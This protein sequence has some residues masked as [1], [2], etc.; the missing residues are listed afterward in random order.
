MDGF[1]GDM[2]DIKDIVVS[3]GFGNFCGALASNHLCDV[4]GIHLDICFLQQNLCEYGVV[5]CGVPMV[6]I[7][8]RLGSGCSNSSILNGE[9][10][11]WIRGKFADF[12]YPRR[13]GKKG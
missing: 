13:T 10:N 3:Y 5:I 11:T 2:E 12:S 8:G 9:V 4:A 1:L 7:V 6:A